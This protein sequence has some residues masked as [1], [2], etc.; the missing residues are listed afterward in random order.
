MPLLAD[1]VMHDQPD[2]EA[3]G[4]RHDEDRPSP[5]M[6]QPCAQRVERR[7]MRQVNQALEQPDA[8]AA[9]EA[10]DECGSAEHHRLGWLQVIKP[11]RQ[12]RL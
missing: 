11:L 8:D 10:D 7:P 5:E 12:R 3:A 6:A 9:R 1:K 4:H 2:E